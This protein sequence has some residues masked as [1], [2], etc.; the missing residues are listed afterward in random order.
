MCWDF[1]C[2]TFQKVVTFNCQKRFQT[3]WLRPTKMLP[4]R[5]EGP[6][7]VTEAPLDIHVSAGGAVEGV[8]AWDPALQMG[9]EPAEV[10]W[11]WSTEHHKKWL[12]VHL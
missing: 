9:G 8:Q 3:I 4:P 7:S 6:N 1:Y 5:K 2:V 10:S 12:C 11:L